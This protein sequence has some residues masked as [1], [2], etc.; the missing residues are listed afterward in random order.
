MENANVR[1]NFIFVVLMIG[2]ILEKAIGGSNLCFGYF[3]RLLTLYVVSMLWNDWNTLRNARSLKT[4]IKFWRVYDLIL[5]IA[6]AF[7]IFFR[8][9][10][11]LDPATENCSCSV[12]SCV[13]VPISNNTL[14][15]ITDP[16]STTVAPPLPKPTPHK[17]IPMHPFEGPREYL[18]DIED[19]LFAF[20]AT[21]AISR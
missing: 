1:I 12:E 2:A 13:R 17:P 9:I 11:V 6:L 21:M 3:H 10:R 8:I 4:F 7:A 14:D 16:T 20:A 5:H 15:P 18:Y 19:M